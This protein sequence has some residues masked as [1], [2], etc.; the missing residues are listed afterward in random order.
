MCCLEIFSHSCYSFPDDLG[1][2]PLP[3]PDALIPLLVPYMMDRVWSQLQPLMEGFNR[4]LEH[5]SRQV[6]DLARDVAQLKSSQL[7]E[8][9]QERDEEAEDEDA[10]LDEVSRSIGEVR[11][12]VET[13]Q[14]EMEQQLHTQNVMLT[15]FRTDMDMKL[16]RQQKTLQVSGPPTPTPT[17]HRSHIKIFHLSTL[18]THEGPTVIFKLSHHPSSYYRLSVFSFQ[19]NE[20]LIK[21]SLV[22]FADVSDSTAVHTPVS[23]LRSACRPSTPR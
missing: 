7:G 18:R 10:R 4:S 22:V 17:P 15:S 6:G 2:A 13:Q 3:Y 12:Q 1:A 5:L 14:S 19:N 8:G 20:L 21:M 11:R 23:D 9:D 16:K